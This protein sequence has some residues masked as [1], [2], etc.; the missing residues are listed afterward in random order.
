MGYFSSAHVDLSESLGISPAQLLG[1]INRANKT[2]NPFEALKIL[3]DEPSYLEKVSLD[4]Q[5]YGAESVEVTGE[6]LE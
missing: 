3:T 6:D 2:K 5:A 1:Q 4:P